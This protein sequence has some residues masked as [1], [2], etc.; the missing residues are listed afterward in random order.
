MDLGIRKTFSCKVSSSFLAQP[1]IHVKSNEWGRFMINEKNQYLRTFASIVVL[2]FLG[3]VAIS[4]LAPQPVQTGE[5]EK[6]MAYNKAKSV[7]KAIASRLSEKAL[8]STRTPAS[9]EGIEAQGYMGTNE[10][11][12]PY[13]YSVLQTSAGVARVVVR[14]GG[15]RGPVEYVEEGGTEVPPPQLTGQTSE[16][17]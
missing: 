1:K 11:G 10:Q 13:H 16:Q 7:G 9:A 4:V 8:S 14:T 15:P 2:S 12:Q 17:Q 6:L 5:S 3:T